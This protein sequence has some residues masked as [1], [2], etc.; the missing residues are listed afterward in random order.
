M[1]KLEQI[2]KIFLER[3]V[4]LYEMNFFFFYQYFPKQKSRSEQVPN[5]YKLVYNAFPKTKQLKE[6]D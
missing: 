2:M 3:V 5:A 4:Y 6:I 1:L